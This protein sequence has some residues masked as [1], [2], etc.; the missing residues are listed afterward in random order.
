V[1]R[2]HAWL[3]DDSILVTVFNN[4]GLSRMSS[5]TAGQ[6]QPFTT[7]GQGELSHRWPSQLPDG[8]AVRYSI[9]NDTGWEAAR[10][11]AQRTGSQEHSVILQDGGYPRDV[12]DSPGGTG[13]LVYARAE[14][15]MAVRFDTA[16]LRTSNAP[17]P[18]VENVMTNLSG[19]A[20]FESRRMGRSPT[21]PVTHQSRFGNSSG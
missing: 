1:P 13:Y 19:G 2:G 12:S 11:A 15:L 4:V 3:A 21:S 14:G 16:T 10:I 6:V 5:S 18:V 20:H 8:S 17:V 7:L 9:W